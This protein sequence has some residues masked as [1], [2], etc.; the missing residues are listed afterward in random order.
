MYSFA[1]KSR[2]RLFI[3]L[4]LLAASLAMPACA[5]KAEKEDEAEA[6]PVEQEPT[7]LDEPPYVGYLKSAPISGMGFHQAVLDMEINPDFSA[8]GSFEGGFDQR[9]FEVPL[10]GKVDRKD[11][12]IELTGQ[13][14][15]HDITVTGDL[16]ARGWE[17]TIAGQVYNEDIDVPMAAQPAEKEPDPDD[18]DI[19]AETPDD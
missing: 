8:T 5:S 7:Q 19:E 3:L 16:S 15:T 13:V 11:G 6:E 2:N 1:T 18:Q 17:G 10:D 9:Y 14:S 12:T 4:V